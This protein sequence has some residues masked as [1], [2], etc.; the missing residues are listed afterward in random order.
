LGDPPVE[1]AAAALGQDRG[2]LGN[3]GGERAHLRADR[4]QV[5]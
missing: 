2:E 5:L 3:A 4:D 1:V